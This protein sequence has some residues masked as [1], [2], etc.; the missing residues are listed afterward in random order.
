MLARRV[1][2]L[3]P[4]RRHIFSSQTSPDVPFEPEVKRQAVMGLGTRRVSASEVVRRIGVSRAVLYKWKDEI[5][6]NSAYQTMRK[7]KEPSLEAECDTLREKVARLNQEICSGT[8]NLA[9]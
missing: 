9:T 2:E 5:I 7:H 4:G 8:V 3:Y 1:N 6:G